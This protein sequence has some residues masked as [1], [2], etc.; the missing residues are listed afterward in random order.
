MKLPHAIDSMIDLNGIS[1]NGP[2]ALAPIAGYSDAPFRRI[3]VRHGASM[4]VTE[5]VSAEGIVRR[6]P[7]SLEYLRFSDDER[8][9]FIQ[10]FG[11]DPATMA[12]A[13]KVAAEYNPDGIDINMG[14]PARKVVTGGAGSALLRDPEKA[15]SVAKAVVEAVNLP[16]SAKI[17][18]GWDHHQR[19][20][21]DVSRAL[22]DGGISFLTV[23]G[24]T[25]AQQ[26]SGEADWDAIGEIA[27]A[28]SIPV[29]GNG[30]IDSH[31][32]GLRKMKEYHCRAVMV[33]RG[34][35]GNPWIFSGAVPTLQER[36]DEALAHL[37]AMIEFAADHGVIMMRK[38]LAKYIHGI[39]NASKVRTE[40]MKAT[41]R[42]GIV[43][44]LSMLG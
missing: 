29:I 15:A 2:V 16:V 4:V 1:L 10:I 7:K 6:I 13:A 42:E 36:I 32:E 18:I 40:I 3:C 23:H 41:T 21:I 11:S 30:D 37:D 26:Y 28:L 44:A 27:S 17:R 43:R 34:A 39:R 19:N 25:R 12:E 31:D 8:P 33:G 20:Y 9:L 35:I 14:C 24:R 38:H 5:L 22:E